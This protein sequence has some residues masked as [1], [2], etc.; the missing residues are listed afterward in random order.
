MS[1]TDDVLS[2]L[3]RHEESSSFPVNSCSVLNDF[4]FNLDAWA[5]QVSK[6][7]EKTLVAVG[8]MKREIGWR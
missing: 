4:C 2:Q 1:I 6:G 8:W 3:N 5:S 7:N